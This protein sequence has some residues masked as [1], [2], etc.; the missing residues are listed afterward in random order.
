MVN[1][2]L[3][4][5]P[6]RIEQRFR[7]HPPHRPDRGVPPVEPGGRGHGRGRR[8]AAIRGGG[9]GPGLGGGGLGLARPGKL[10][11]GGRPAA[12]PDRGDPLRRPTRG[13]RPPYARRAIEHGVDRRHLGGPGRGAGARPRR[14][15]T[16]AA[17]PAC[18]RR[19]SAP[20]RAAC[21][22]TTSSRV[23]SLEAFKRLGGTVRQ[24]EPRRCATPNVITLK[25]YKER[26]KAI[27]SI[28]HSKH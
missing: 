1:Y 22:R 10:R 8:G 20:R 4:W 15:R 12:P 28:R 3:P 7:P 13:P 27:P 16:R 11:R 18:A 17:W 9:R 6:N 24:R 19:W 2:D 5:N 26:T 23:L 14:H 21:S 25:G